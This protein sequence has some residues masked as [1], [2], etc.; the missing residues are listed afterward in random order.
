MYIKFIFFFFIVSS[1][2]FRAQISE[3][4]NIK[5]KYLNWLTDESVNTYS[6]I[7][8]KSLYDKYIQL[9]NTAETNVVINYN[10]TSPGAPWNMTNAIDD[11]AMV[12][13]VNNY[14]FYLVSSYHLKGPLVNGQPSNPKY[15]STQRKDVI[16]KVFKYIKDKGI[17]NTTDFDFSTNPSQ[18]TININNSEFGVRCFTYAICVLLMKNELVQA[19]EFSHHMGILENLTSFLAP[20]NSNFNFTYPGFNTDVVKALLETRFCYILGLDDSDPDKVGNMNHFIQFTNNALQ[21]SNGWSDFLKP[22]YTTYHHRGV[23]SGA[24]GGAALMSVSILNYILKG[25]AYQLSAVSENNIKKALITYQ[26]F[27]ADFEMPRGLN[28]RFPGSTREFLNVKNAY[29]MLYVA[30]PI[31]NADMGAAFKRMYNMPS[32]GFNR[33]VNTMN[34]IMAGQIAININNSGTADNPITQGHFDFPYAGLSVHKYNG[35]QISVKGTGKHIWHYE[36]NATENRFG[37]Y[38][39][40]GAME[41]LSAGTIKTRLS[42]GLGV[43]DAN[44]NVT[45]NGWDW[46]HLPGVTAAYMPLAQLQSG[47]ARE[48]NGKNFLAHASLDDNGIFAMDYKDINSATGMTAL[49]TTFFLK[50]KALSL[51]SDIKDP[52][53]TYPIH[54][55]VFQT[56]LADPASPT[57]INGTQQTGLNVN[58]SQ[59]SGN[60]WAT[61]AVGNG[62]VIPAGSYNGSVTIKRSTQQSRNSANTTDTQ[63]NYATAYIDHGTAPSSGTYRY[64]IILQGGTT[65]TQDFAANLNNYFEVL[66]QNTAAHVVKFVQ[67]NIYNYVVFDPDSVFQS[68]AFISTDKPSVVITQKINGGSKLKISVTNPSLGLLADNEAYTWSQISGTASRL[69]RVPQIT[70]VKVKLAGKWIPESVNSSINTSIIGNNTEVTFNTIN[71][72][73]IQT[74]LVPEAVLNVQDFKDDNENFTICSNP[75]KGKT[76]VIFKNNSI[77]TIRIMDMSGKDVTSGVHMV[78]ENKKIY[79]DVNNLATGTYM[80]CADHTCKKL[81]KQ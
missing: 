56:G 77:S 37:R 74:T 47:I 61:D 44:G 69:Y 18:E 79:L 9:G 13:L 10:F 68:D 51:G 4:N 60:V 21:I 38:T 50:D 54:T 71:G 14:L 41:I 28:G 20:D 66:Q 33:T 40:A 48:F 46:A 80:I 22:D 7:N 24:Y 52:G 58:Y 57:L 6:N 78:K 59:S 19:G 75:S 53:G 26:K 1:S 55:T 34:P 72:L 8:V 27:C 16:L 2:L 62:F 45:D 15:H 25:S 70:P 23:Y 76:S 64:G 49:K 81:I 35:Y 36:S 42:N 11:M 12:T 63:G 32:S 39:S 5:T 29:A 3:I 31:A 73:T 17:S 67:E 43:A 30:D 65:G